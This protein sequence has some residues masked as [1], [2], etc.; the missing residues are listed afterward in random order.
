MVY[1]L[2]FRVQGSGFR[3][4]G[5]GF[6]VYSLRFTVEVRNSVVEIAFQDEKMSQ[7]IAPR[8]LIL[9]EN[10]STFCRRCNI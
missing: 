6:K 5:S 1:G 4:Q 9:E 7:N 8:F 2:G 10:K 3:V